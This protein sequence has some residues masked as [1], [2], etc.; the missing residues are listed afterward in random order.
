[1]AAKDWAEYK[2]VYMIEP[3]M[4][5]DPSQPTIAIIEDV[6][7]EQAIDQETG[8]KYDR[9]LLFLVGWQVP[10]RL[11]NTL[12]D[13]IQVLFGS[14]PAACIGGRISL[15]PEM[16]TAYGKSKLAVG[17]DVVPVDQNAMAT[18][19][20]ARFY[21]QDKERMM[22]A[23]DSGVQRIR[24]NVFA[25]LRGTAGALGA[26][27]AARP[28]PGGWAA[29]PVPSALPA[30]SSKPMGNDSAVGLMIQLAS[31]GKDWGWMVN[32]LMRVG[33]GEAV[34]GRI[35]PESDESI[36]RVVWGVIKDLPVVRDFSE[37]E[38][39]HERQRL[40]SS[41]E[42]PAAAPTP[43]A[44]PAAVSQAVSGE[45][46]NHD[47]GEVTKPAAPLNFKPSKAPAP[48]VNDD[49]IPF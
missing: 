38:V 34:Q 16:R 13:T 47:T 29:P 6:K 44:E 24:T 49:D 23:E 10:L 35:P 48:A 28:Q 1:M 21:V 7:T 41:W 2:A 5:P 26:G 8:E 25:A 20:P 33:M 37:Q 43:A 36:K 3:H 12:I 22:L 30:L 27:P 17:I 42:P 32:H 45:V 19:V 15:K 18:P 4:L 39:A 9:T 11:N 46:V 40:V 31:R 14:S